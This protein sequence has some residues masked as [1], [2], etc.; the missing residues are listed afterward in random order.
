[1]KRFSASEKWDDPW[2]RKMRPKFKLFFNFLC[3][4]CD[5]AG[6]WVIDMESVSYYLGERIDP[7]DALTSFEGRVVDMG[8]GKWLLT[9]FIGFQ[10]SELTPACIPH[11]KIIE[12]VKRHGI[13][14]SGG[15]STLPTTLVSTLREGM[16]HTLQE[17]D[18][19]KDKEEDKEKDGES[20][21][22]ESDV[23]LGNADCN[24]VTPP[25]RKSGR[26]QPMPESPDEAVAL[27]MTAG[28]PEEFIRRLYDQCRGVGFIDGQGRAIADW[29][30]YA[31][32]RH[33][34]EQSIPK[35]QNGN[36]KPLSIF[37]LKSVMAAKETQAQDIRRK[38]CSE[39]ATGD[40]WSDPLKREDYRKL[41]RE[42]K[43][44]NVQIGGFK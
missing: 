5:N 28:L 21:G 20:E 31:K 40:T 23:T 39:V 34:R 9:K 36:G 42:I 7:K 2:F 13:V 11:R 35:G 17:E 27:C 19:D 30:Y 32:Q 41:R 4:K 22:G 26:E 24:F 18:K 10:Y 1:M 16:A 8:N 12:L 37:E 3:D 43:E 25:S 33:N 38:F 14:V 15:I 29:P 6:V 44:I